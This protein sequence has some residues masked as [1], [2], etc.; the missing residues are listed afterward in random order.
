MESH[1]L[2]ITPTDVCHC[3]ARLPFGNALPFQNKRQMEFEIKVETEVVVVKG[4][5][6]LRTESLTPP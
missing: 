2:Q 3:P 6:Y 4:A 1:P 5:C